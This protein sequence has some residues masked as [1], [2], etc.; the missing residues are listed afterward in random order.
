M[1]VLS[2]VITRHPR[3]SIA[4]I[5][6]LV[7]VTIFLIPHSY[8]YT[9]AAVYF[10][11]RMSSSSLANILALQEDY[12]KFHLERREALVQRYGPTAE[13]VESFPPGQQYYTLWDFFI[14]AF[15][16]PHRVERIGNL[17]DGGKWVCGLDRVAK[18]KECVIY[19]FGLNGEVSFEA[20]LLQLAPGCQLWGYDYSVQSIG[21]QIELAVDQHNVSLSSR[22][23]FQAYALGGKDTHNTEPPMYTLKTLLESNGHKFIDIL[24]IDIESW[25]F[26]SLES[27]V[28]DYLQPG[29]VLPV[30]Q[31]Q[32]EIHAT[33]GSGY[34]GFA[35]FKT[36]WEKLETAGLRPFWTEPNLVYLNI[37]RNVRPDL[38]EYSFINIRGEHAL[39]SDKWLS[40]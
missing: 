15:Q 3:Y 6:L 4:G 9:D 37:I 25:E 2:T 24:K 39:V 21:P 14:P 10:R 32:L 22:A 27:F 16:C 38:A 7:L 34:G 18:Q 29:A 35:K 17:G 28:A 11:T 20:E 13:E 26:E 33:E 31:M 5:F 19:S 23:H 12:Y 1:A 30:G 8:D 36:W 40:K